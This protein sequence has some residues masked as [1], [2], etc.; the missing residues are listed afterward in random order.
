MTRAES[1]RPLG[2]IGCL[3]AGF[4]IVSRRVW[5]VLLP[6]LIDMFLWLGPRLSMSPVLQS[7]ISFMSAQTVPDPTTAR[8]AAEAMQI[9]EQFGQE[10]S[11]FSLLSLL[12]LLNVPSLLAHHTLQAVSPLGEPHV[13]SI[14]SLLEL[15]GW[16]ILL[17]PIGL[18]L[19]FLY[20][21]RLA[22]WVS[23]R[24]LPDE[25]KAISSQTEG[26]NKDVLVLGGIGKFIRFFLFAIGLLLFAVIFIFLWA[27]IVGIATLIAP[28]LGLLIGM[29]GLGLAN[30]II[31]H[32]LFVIPGVMLGERGLWRATWES[33]G[34]MHTQFLSTMGFLILTAVIYGGLGHIWLL[35]SADSWLLLIGILGNSCVTTALTAASF[36]FYQERIMQLREMVQL[37]A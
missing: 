21:D 20:L 15:I 36:V 1:Y 32:L 12:P 30:Y 17:L 35:P 7:L 16:G 5:L 27:V 34:L 24:R 28:F 33:A 18:V 2:V 14:M 9:L 26:E 31:L 4:E 19:G 23:A 25:Q 13:L 6:V 22:H 3:T 8:Q 11:G 29:I 10:F 37:S